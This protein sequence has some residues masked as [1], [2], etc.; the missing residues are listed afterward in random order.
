MKIEVF[1]KRGRGGGGVVAGWIA[2][3][4]V[5]V[6]TGRSQRESYRDVAWLEEFEEVG[7][8]S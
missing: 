4:D 1:R 5:G 6:V 2:R 3:D 7:M 8:V